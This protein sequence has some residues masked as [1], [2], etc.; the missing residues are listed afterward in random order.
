[1]KKIKAVSILLLFVLQVSGQS[2]DFL[3]GYLVKGPD[4]LRGFVRREKNPWNEKQILFKPS[5]YK[6]TKT[7]QASEISA[8]FI[9][10]TDEIFVRRAVSVDRT[11]LKMKTLDKK[12]TPKM[13]ADT[14][15]LR[16][17]VGGSLGL[18]YY[19]DVKNHFFI[20]NDQ[21]LEE[22]LFIKYIPFGIDL[23][24]PMELEL[25]NAQL[26][27]ITMNC[28]PGSWS[29]VLYNERPIV[30]VISNYNTCKSDLKYVR[31]KGKPFFNATLLVG[32]SITN[33]DYDGI[34]NTDFSDR[35]TA[36]ITN[37]SSS[38][39][40]IYGGSFD[41]SRKMNAS[42]KLNAELIFRTPSTFT[43]SN[44]ITHQ[45]N[46]RRDYSI[47]LNYTSLN[48]G[49]KTV[50]MRLN[51]VTVQVQ[52]NL[53][54][55]FFTGTET[56]EIQTLGQ[57]YNKVSPMA[58]F[59]SVGSGFLGALQLGYRGLLVQARWENMTIQSP[60]S[61]S[62]ILSSFTLAAGISLKR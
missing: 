37:F 23:K 56:Y 46:T 2:V 25:Y 61:S 42:I 38:A 34:S 27:S 47:T 1:M 44:N 41:F 19:H 21:G 48:F 3:K 8:F 26:D 22:L 39:G 15:F 55:G 18:H 29:R 50:V 16:K 20:E 14:V 24:K 5:R 43:G 10:S 51:G 36:S 31:T 4:T 32:S 59:G 60:E 17:L 52:G 11:P 57:K 49:F 54:R 30:K 53:T 6:K 62:V 28:R 7:F 35:Y 40:P 45:R 9:E 13:E 12:P 58:N 33:A